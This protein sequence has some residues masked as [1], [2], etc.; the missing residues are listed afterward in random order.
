[1]TGWNYDESRNP[2]DVLMDAWDRNEP[3]ELDS[4]NTRS[5]CPTPAARWSGRTPDRP[6]RT[7]QHIRSRGLRGLVLRGGNGMTAPTVSDLAD[8]ICKHGFPYSRCPVES[9]TDSGTSKWA[10]RTG[11]NAIA[12][13]WVGKSTIEVELVVRTTKRFRVGDDEEAVALVE[14]MFDAGRLRR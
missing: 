13:K 7:V 2:N 6:L 11:D 14:A 10:R 12:Y 5:D 4:P 8:K 3:W 1:M 9:C